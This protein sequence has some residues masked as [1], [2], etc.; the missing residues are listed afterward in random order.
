MASREKVLGI[1]KEVE[2]DVDES[3]ELYFMAVVRLATET[4]CRSDV[5]FFKG[6]DGTGEEGVTLYE[7]EN[8]DTAGTME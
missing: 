3:D 1:N 7:F 2:E 8:E 6:E 5:C 4:A